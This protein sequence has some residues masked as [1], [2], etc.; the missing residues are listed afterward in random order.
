MPDRLCAV[1]AW[2]MVGICPSVM[3]LDLSPQSIK[4][5]KA[6]SLVFLY[7]WRF[8]RGGTLVSDLLLQCLP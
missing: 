7:F 8:P 6:C 1:A 2:D 5:N 4:T 3:R